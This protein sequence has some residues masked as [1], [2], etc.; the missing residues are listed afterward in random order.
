MTRRITPEGCDIVNNSTPVISFGNPTEAR[1]ATLGIN[2]SNIEF[3]KDGVP[4]S[5]DKRRLA[6]LLSIGAESTESMS[7]VQ[8]QEVIDDCYNYF[9]Q[10]PYKEWFGPLDKILKVG[11]N[12]SYFDG[13]ACHLDLV[14]WA[15]ATKWKGLSAAVR[16]KL[17]KESEVH[18]VNQLQAENITKIVVNGRAV[19]DELKN[20]KLV[21]YEEIK[22]IYFGKEGGH[23]TSCKLRV[24]HGCGATFY[25][26]TSNIQ[27]QNGANDH[28]FRQKLGLWLEE[29]GN[30]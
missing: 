18:L 10:N 30:G 14:H 3:M 21:K 13:S 22:T 16:E 9:N 2:P 12:A 5:G 27:S 7:N 8:I 23:Q 29:V 26:W 11:F 15:T 24:G 1:I 25:G 28:I 6:T 17:L 19:W 20:L 4:L